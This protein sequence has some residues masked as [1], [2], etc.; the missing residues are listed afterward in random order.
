M[1]P[2]Y[3]QMHQTPTI[4]TAYARLLFDYLRALGRNPASILPAAQVAEI[5]TNHSHAQTSRT[6]WLEMIASITAQSDDPNLALKIGEAFQV[7]HLGVAG[8]VL[9][10]CATLGEAG[11]QVVRYYRLMG[12]V[13]SSQ[14]HRRGEWAEDIFQWTEAGLPPPVLEQL[15]AAA[16]V[17]LGRWLTGCNDLAWEAHFRF[18]RPADISAYE[19]IFQGTL[20]FGQPATKLVFPAHVL[21]L[22][23]AMGNPELRTMAEAQA[24]AIL[25][26]LETEPEILRRT[27][28]LIEQR[29][30]IGR[31]SLDEVAP[32]LGLSART[33][34]RRLAECGCSFRELV[35][36]VR[37]TRAEVFLRNPTVTLA[38]IAFLLGYSEQST[39]QH[40]FKRWT[41][42][43]PGEF[44]TG[45]TNTHHT[46]DTPR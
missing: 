7:R 5:E 3:P 37:R 8:Y 30:G 6:A 29:L 45:I 16:T 33:L 26:A 35:D 11:Q 38:E 36:T 14:V 27:R 18:P 22:P 39:F 25:K 44:R 23:I 2:A 10:S 19:R 9:I 1:S 41:G 13:G 28:L 34:H 17:T 40:A 42:Q 15:W 21:E 46:F 24:A 12:D 4:S 20:H 31:A 43:T 32:M